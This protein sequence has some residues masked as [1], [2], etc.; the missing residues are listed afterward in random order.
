LAELSSKPSS[1]SSPT[2]FSGDE[3][4][5]FVIGGGINGAGI[6][7]D[8]A[9]RGLTVALAER[10]DL[11]GGTSSASSKLVHGGLRYLEHYEFRLVRESL[12]ERE[13]LLR[14]APHLVRPLRFVM[15][16]QPARRP[17]WMI[18]L[19]LFLYDH[20]GGHSS[21]PASE[22]VDL[23]SQWGAG[24]K[25][26]FSRGFAYSDC[27]VDDARLVVLNA[28]DAARNGA[29]I[30]TRTE[31]VAA[32]R[33]GTRWHVTTEER[34]TGARRVFRARAL[35]NAAG[36]WVAA[37][38]ETV[39]GIKPRDRLRLVK[40]S[41]VVVPRLYQGEQAYLLQSADGRIVFIIPFEERFS[42]IGTTEVALD[43]AP[44]AVGILPEEIL[45]L[46]RVV[47]SFLD[48]SFEDGEIAW[49]F[50]GIRPLYDDGSKDPSAVTRDYVLE[51]DGGKG[52]PPLLSVFGGKITTYRRLA[53]HALDKLRPTFPGMKPAWTSQGTL[54]GGDVGPGGMLQF[55][56][57][58]V[59]SRPQLPTEL[60]RRLARRHGSEVETLLGSARDAADLGRHFGGLLYEREVEHFIRQE[61]ARTVDDIIWRRSKS[62]LHMPP[63]GIAAL[64]D[65]LARQPGGLDPPPAGAE[66]R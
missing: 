41:H 19:G 12:A 66:T 62:G 28:R 15:P 4:D 40:G 55:I 25:Q 56:S 32:R 44:A 27:R 9:G 6:A 16:Y 36:P 7:R 20:L 63:E 61:W 46:R 48:R 57:R 37:V 2:P 23:A 14:I 8:A 24:I 58:L 33:E 31:C 64:A 30:M 3:I 45:Y 35:V 47:A 34:R 42:L 49:S 29:L 11:A 43:A 52:A 51:L 39:A 18:R 60:L 22:G 59:A 21:L 54:P 13:V 38:A 26:I 53:E 5:L 10:D 50:A 1:G 65:Y 17:A